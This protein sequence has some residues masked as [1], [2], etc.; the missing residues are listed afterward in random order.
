MRCEEIYRNVVHYVKPVESGV[1]L[2][3]GFVLSLVETTSAMT[4][5]H[6]VASSILA[7]APFPRFPPSRKIPRS[8]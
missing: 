6:G 2:D 7:S 4:E 3:L 8:P 5:N 1:V